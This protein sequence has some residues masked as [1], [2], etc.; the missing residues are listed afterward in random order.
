M[1]PLHEKQD[2]NSPFSCLAGRNQ[3]SVYTI[4]VDQMIHAAPELACPK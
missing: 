3:H 4:Q 1:L 2:Y